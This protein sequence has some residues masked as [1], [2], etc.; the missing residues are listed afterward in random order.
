[1]VMDGSVVVRVNVH[2]NSTVI[3]NE[4]SFNEDAE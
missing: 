2:N 4:D 3:I 1:M